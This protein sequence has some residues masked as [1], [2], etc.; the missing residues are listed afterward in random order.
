MCGASRSFMR[1]VITPLRRQ[2][3]VPKLFTSCGKGFVSKMLLNDCNRPL[4]LVQAPSHRVRSCP[5]DGGYGGGC[6]TILGNSFENS[7]RITGIGQQPLA[8]L[9]FALPR[10]HHRGQC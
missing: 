6:I 3:G 1:A 2:L 5:I 8:R 9:Q 4:L 10:Q 7:C